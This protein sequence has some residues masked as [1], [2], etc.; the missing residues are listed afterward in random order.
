MKRY[1]PYII[2]VMVVLLLAVAIFHDIYKSD[3]RIVKYGNPAYERLLRECRYYK[4]EDECLVVK[5]YEGKNSSKGTAWYSVTVEKPG[6]AETQIFISSGTPGVDSIGLC[7]K[8]IKMMCGKGC[9]T[10]PVD[11][12]DSKIKV[13]LIYYNGEMSKD[14][15]VL[16]DKI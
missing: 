4:T 1:S 10:I 5:L 11:E 12:L 9:V 7:E 14:G 15:E 2:A 8:E 16:S 13:P 3:S 6:I